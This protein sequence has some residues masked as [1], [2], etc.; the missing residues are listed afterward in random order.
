[1][2]RLVLIPAVL[3]V[4][5]LAAF[6]VV[7]AS[8]STPFNGSFSGTFTL[9]SS[10]TKA[11]VTGSGVREHM[12]ETSFAAQVPLPAQHHAS[13]DLLRP[14]K[15]PSRQRTVTRC[16]HHQTMSCVQLL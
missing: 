13:T 10:G 15:K 11:T 14:S 4:M 12:G 9:T 3:A 8:H 5:V 16:S 2:K 1:M 7:F 6:P